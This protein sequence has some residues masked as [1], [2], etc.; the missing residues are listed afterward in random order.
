MVRVYP[1]NTLKKY[2][3]LFTG[4]QRSMVNQQ[5]A[6]M[7]VGR[8]VRLLVDLSGPDRGMMN[9]SQMSEDL[10]L[11]LL[12]PRDRAQGAPV[13]GALALAH[14][15]DDEHAVVEADQ[16]ELAGLATQIARKNFKSAHLQVLRRKLLG[17]RAALRA[18]ILH[19][20]SC[21]AA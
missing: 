21:R 7:S 15:D 1:V 5:A 17:G 3:F 6:M 8:E 13:L 20:A 4:S 2:F 16:I 18:Q 10:E 12:G 14:L 9:S 11:A 19:A